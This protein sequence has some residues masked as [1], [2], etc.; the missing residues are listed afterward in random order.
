VS[1]KAT[2]AAKP[3]KAD[4][5]AVVVPW[6][7]GPMQ[8]FVLPNWTA[9]TIGRRIFSWR[10]LDE[11]ELAHEMAHVKQWSEYGLSFIV[12]YFL[13]SR[14]AKAAGGDRYWDNIYE[15]EATEAAEKVRK[16][17]DR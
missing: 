14:A 16:T 8:R 15:K 7:K 2:K 9:I 13:A 5:T 4:H 3:P 10:K 17:E 11:I 1:P 12:R 6:L